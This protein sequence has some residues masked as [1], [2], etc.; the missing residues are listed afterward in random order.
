MKIIEFKEM[1]TVIAKNQQPYLPFP[2]FRNIDGEL[3][4]CWKLSWLERIKV[5]FTG[6]IWHRILTFNQKLQPQLLEIN[7]PKFL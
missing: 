5:L 7:K 1:N 4:A 3:I 2:C 6:I